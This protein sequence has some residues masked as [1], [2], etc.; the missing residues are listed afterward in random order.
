[1]SDTSLELA[2]NV[3]SDLVSSK[4]GNHNFSS[5]IPRQNVRTFSQNITSFCQGPPPS[6]N[7]R[8]FSPLSSLK[9]FLS[10][11]I[12]EHIISCTNYHLELIK[13]DWR[14]NQNLFWKWI[15]VLYYLGI[16]KGKN[17]NVQEAFNKDFGISFLS[18]CKYSVSYDNFSKLWDTENL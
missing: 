3:M 11:D 6:L 9:L 18:K 13:K 2:S 14:L 16:M 10:D 12:V 15:G 7:S 4:D 1:M 17:M 8:I 5:Q